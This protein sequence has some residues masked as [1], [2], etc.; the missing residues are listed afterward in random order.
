MNIDPAQ[1]Q[2]RMN[3]SGE[4]GYT[5]LSERNKACLKGEATMLFTLPTNRVFWNRFS[6]KRESEDLSINQLNVS[7]SS[8]WGQLFGIDKVFDK[9]KQQ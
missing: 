7:A 2:V 8:A 4:A 5:L 6:I 3:F 9:K 1:N